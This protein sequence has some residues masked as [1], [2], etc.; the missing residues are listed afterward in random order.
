MLPIIVAT[1]CLL[2]VK[3]Q[4]HQPATGLQQDAPVKPRVVPVT[5]PPVP[6][7]PSVLPVTKNTSLSDRLGP[8]PP[9]PNSGQARPAAL[10]TAPSQQFIVAELFVKKYLQQ[11]HVKQVF[12]FDSKLDDAHRPQA[13]VQ[14]FP[15]T[16]GNRLWQVCAINTRFGCVY[17]SLMLDDNLGIPAET[18]GV[19]ITYQDPDLEQVLAE[20]HEVQVNRFGR[21]LFNYQKTVDSEEMLRWFLGDQFYPYSVGSYF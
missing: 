3:V 2:V 1:L 7:S 18:P 8:R 11:P 5:E 10:S 13:Y 19:L 9:T 17:L 20:S 14:R 4:H 12:L 16:Q 15:S 21:I 6:N